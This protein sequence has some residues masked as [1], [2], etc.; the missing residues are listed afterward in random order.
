MG[1]KKGLIANNKYQD[2]TFDCCIIKVEIIS[3]EYI[4]IIDLVK[5]CLQNS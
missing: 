3:S 5:N 2:N 1:R 4:I